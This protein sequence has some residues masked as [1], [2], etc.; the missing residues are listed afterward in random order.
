MRNALL[1]R[2]EAA[3]LTV[4]AGNWIELKNVMLECLRSGLVREDDPYCKDSLD[5]VFKIT[6][7]LR[8]VESHHR[9]QLHSIVKL[10]FKGGEIPASAFQSVVDLKNLK[11]TGSA[12]KV[13]TPTTKAK[14]DAAAASATKNVNAATN[15]VSA[16]PKQVAADAKSGA[17][18]TPTGAVKEGT[19]GNRGALSY[20]VKF[21][22]EAENDEAENDKEV[23][24]NAATEAPL[25]PVITPFHDESWM[26]GFWASLE[27]TK[28][29]AVDSA[30]Y[31]K[32]TDALALNFSADIVYGRVYD[33]MTAASAA[34][35]QV[36][37]APYL[38]RE[39][40]TS[41]REGCSLAKSWAAARLPEVSNFLC[42]KAEVEKMEKEMKAAVLGEVETAKRKKWGGNENRG[43]GAE[44]GVVGSN[45]NVN[46]SNGTNTDYEE[47]SISDNF[48]VK[49]IR[50]VNFGN[51]DANNKAGRSRSSYSSYNEDF[52]RNDDDNNNSNKNKNNSNDDNNND[53]TEDDTN[54]ITNVHAED[55]EA[56]E[57]AV[58]DVI[59]NVD[60]VV[61]IAESEAHAPEGFDN[62][63]HDHAQDLGLGLRR[64]SMSAASGS[65]L[66]A[67]G[68]NSFAA[69]EESSI[70]RNDNENHA[71]DLSLGL[72]RCRSNMS[73]AAGSSLSAVLES[74]LL[75]AGGRSLLA[76]G[77][78]STECNNGARRVSFGQSDSINR[79]TGEHENGCNNSNNNNDNDSIDIGNNNNENPRGNVSNNAAPSNVPKYVPP[80]SAASAAGA[81][82]K[83]DLPAASADKTSS[84]FDQA[85]HLDQSI[86]GESLT[87]YRRHLLKEAPSGE[88]VQRAERIA[89]MWENVVEVANASSATSGVLDSIAAAA[90]AFIDAVRVF[91]IDDPKSTVGGSLR[92][93]PT[94][95]LAHA[96]MYIG[97]AGFPCRGA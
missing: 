3:A 19:V 8:N 71:H 15:I 16:A 39:T 80:A 68:E 58:N 12:A 94:S 14:E 18:A 56:E 69:A 70:V 42:K 49:I 62:S 92:T 22:N 67:V 57:E 84:H 55:L 87:S 17:K 23:A 43:G 51:R 83:Q 50:A 25:P 6:K 64:R 9:R 59:N 24:A 38:V 61:D 4:R 10:A 78:N 7:S 21:A 91:K 79:I 29:L 96:G 35:V 72:R 53:N 81:R 97:R 65:S 45:S 66:S 11:K 75:S 47:L 37:L 31:V 88:E 41:L 28:N 77:E 54:N 93:F 86:A 34:V 46:Q 30:F 32:M 33:G 26:N 95:V 27:T 90:E 73:A 48:V 20:K 40:T 13:V 63:R 1:D 76:E 85:I 52:D 5:L 44:G 74:S 60:D 89:K 82:A 36:L 2:L